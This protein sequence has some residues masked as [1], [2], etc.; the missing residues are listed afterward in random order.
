MQDCFPGLPDTKQ[1]FYKLDSEVGIQEFENNQSLFSIFP[2]PVAT[3][4]IS[5]LLEVELKNALF[6][7]Y[8]SEGKLVKSNTIYSKQF[9]IDRTDLSAGFYYISIQNKDQ[10][11]SAKKIILL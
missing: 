7:I 9:K 6:F 5:I 11:L 2:N 3:E 10:L 8:N 1:D 4:D